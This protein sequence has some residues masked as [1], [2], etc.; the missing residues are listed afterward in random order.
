MA[1]VGFVVGFLGQAGSG[2]G[3]QKQKSQKYPH[4][5][6]SFFSR[7]WAAEPGE[8]REILCQIRERG[9]GGF[10]Q[11]KTWVIKESIATWPGWRA[12]FLAFAIL[13]SFAAIRG[14]RYAR[15]R[16]LAIHSAASFVP[17]L[18]PISCVAF[19]CCTAASTALLIR[20]ASLAKPR[21]S[22]IIA[23]VEIAPMGLAMFFP[24]KG[25]AEP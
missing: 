3:Q 13:T 1:G 20:S 18:P 6:T 5:C 4:R 12:N 14:P 8:E 25:G 7:S 2:A 17:R 11:Q 23:A 9:S 16:A 22:S 15:D 24:A 19:F 21:W 10:L